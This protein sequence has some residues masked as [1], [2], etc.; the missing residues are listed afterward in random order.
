[1]AGDIATA[2]PHIGRGGWSWYTGSAA[3]AYRLGTEAILGIRYRDKYLL[4]D[5]CIPKSWGR[6]SA[7]LT[8][9][10]GTI[11]LAVKDPEGVGCGVIQISVNGKAITG[12]QV[13]LPSDNELLSVEVLLGKR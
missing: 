9:E 3:W 7:T 2:G 1:M 10:N 12:Q 4:I 11:E 8:R 6:Y 5:P 13:A